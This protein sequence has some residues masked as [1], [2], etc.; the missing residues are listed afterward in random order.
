MA[1]LTKICWYLELPNLIFLKIYKLSFFF[2]L[3]VYI[4]G[5]LSM[6]KIFSRFVYSNRVPSLV[7]VGG[8][9]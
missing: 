3:Y 6:W 2:S 9:P 7:I 5:I 4:S 8:R 1:A